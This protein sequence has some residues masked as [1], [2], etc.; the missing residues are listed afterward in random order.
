MNKRVKI[1]RYK[2]HEGEEPVSVDLFRV[3]RHSADKLQP[4]CIPC[5]KKYHQKRYIEKRQK[6]LDN[7]REYYETNK[8]KVSIRHA[9]WR[10]ENKEYTAQYWKEYDSKHPE[11]RK[12]KCRK[13]QA[14]KKNA[15]PAWLTEDQLFEMEL[16][17]KNCPVGYEVD[18]IVPIQGKN[19]RGLHVPWN[20]QYLTISENRRKHNKY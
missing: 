3:A 14:S 2:E 1:C 20:L 5:E 13:Y 12:A 7:S 19:V 4:W 10:E 9:A 15:L 6:I 8:S 11:K 17:Y 18:H 16:I